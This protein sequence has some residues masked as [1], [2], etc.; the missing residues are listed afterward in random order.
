MTNEEKIEALKE[1]ADW[2]GWNFRDDYSGRG[3]YGSMCAAIS[4]DSAT[5]I[6]EAA[7]ERGIKGASQDSMGLGAVVYWQGIKTNAVNA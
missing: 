4:G 3:M 7:A 1:I 2:N 5:N 6:I